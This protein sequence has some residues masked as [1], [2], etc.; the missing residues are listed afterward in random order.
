MLL[1]AAILGIVQGLAEFLPISSTGHLI[2]VEHFFGLSQEKFGLTFDAALH[3][4]TLF[5]IIIYFRKE[6]YDLIIAFLKTFTQGFSDKE[7]KLSWYIILA[8]IPGAFF[9]I[10]FEKKVETIFR[11]P[12][13]VG[14]AL[15]IFSAVLWYADKFSRKNKTITDVGVRDSIIIGLAQALALV[16]GISR[17]GATIAAAMSGG[18]K[19]EDAAHFAFLLS[20]PIILG[21]GGKTLLDIVKLR[22]AQVYQSSDILFFT[23][24]IVFAA[25]SGYITIRFFLNYLS[26]NTLMP[27]IWYRV[28]LGVAV[29]VS[30]LLIG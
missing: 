7:T 21:A 16:P 15:I 8:T 10:L 25:I 5:A 22:Q 29:L 2:I 17:S 4:G 28:L 6:I 9:G 20:G 3:L 30:V 26:K 1:E 23:I 24:G 11:S 19:R 13:L 27:F 18:L 14:L 12:V